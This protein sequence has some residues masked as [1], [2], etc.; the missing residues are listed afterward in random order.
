MYIHYTHAHS[1]RHIPPILSVYV[2]VY[3]VRTMIFIIVFILPETHTP[4]LCSATKTASGSQALNR[5]W[6]SWGSI[7]PNT[8]GNANLRNISI[9]IDDR[10]LKYSILMDVLSA[11]RFMFIH[12]VCVYCAYSFGPDIAILS[13][14]S[15][16]Y[17]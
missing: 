15:Q 16:F 3:V 4:S 11:L 8:L 6:C 14:P 1:M 10:F 2:Y 12:T 7:T 17:F 5:Y 13:R 9:L